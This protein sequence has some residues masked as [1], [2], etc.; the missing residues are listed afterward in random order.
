MLS[1]SHTSKAKY[2]PTLHQNLQQTR[3]SCSALAFATSGTSH[4]GV[5]NAAQFQGIV[6]AFQG[7]TR[8]LSECA[9]VPFTPVVVL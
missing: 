3:S 1:T 6:A 2:E 5:S 4:V 7:S 9:D 8:L